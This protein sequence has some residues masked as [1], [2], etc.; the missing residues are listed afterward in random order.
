MFMAAL[1]IIAK[2]ETTQM[3][4]K[5]WHICTMNYIIQ[6]YKEVYIIK[7]YNADE[8]CREKSKGKSHTLL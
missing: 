7:C 8:P 3:S 1:F 4:I 2:M 5:M 6:P